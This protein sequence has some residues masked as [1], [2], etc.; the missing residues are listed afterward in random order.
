MK[1]LFLIFLLGCSIVRFYKT[2][3]INDQMETTL[4]RSGIFVQQAQNYKNQTNLILR[5]IPTSHK[6]QQNL[7]LRITEL[8]QKFNLFLDTYN[9]LKS[10]KSEFDHLIIGKS[11]IRS[12]GPDWRNLQIVKNKFENLANDLSEQS[13]TYQTLAMQFVEIVNKNGLYKKADVTSLSHNL[14]TNLQKVE[15]DFTKLK[16]DFSEKNELCIELMAIIKS[17]QLPPYKKL[18]SYIKLL[19]QYVRTIKSL[20]LQ[21]NESKK[22][23][24][25]I[26][27]GK[28]FI[29]SIDDEFDQFQKLSSQIT[30]TTQEIN[31]NLSSYNSLAF[32]FNKVALQHKIAKVQTIALKTKIEMATTS[33]GQNINAIKKSLKSQKKKIITSKNINKDPSRKN[34]IKEME[35]ILT[36]L[37]KENVSIQKMAKRFEKESRGKKSFWV[38]PGMQSYTLLS[39]IKAKTSIISQKVSQFNQ[40]IQ[41]YNAI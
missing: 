29:E 36:L 15:E 22:L 41:K 11:K 13:K 32:E 35:T 4:S 21:L 34:L 23:I 18:N 7:S 31:D 39:D 8:N 3:D 33:F 25:K 1:S 6:E 19:S 16:I 38:G 10:V 20:Q 28:T 9:K 12:D 5:K 17:S 37:E 27:N 14:K 24:L 40:L 2:K 30:I 26:T